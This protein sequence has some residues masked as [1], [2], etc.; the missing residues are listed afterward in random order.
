MTID[1]LIRKLETLKASTDEGGNTEV[2]FAIEAELPGE[3]VFAPVIIEHLEVR[4]LT[5][6]EELCN[7]QVLDKD[8]TLSEDEIA[9]QAVVINC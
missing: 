7:M 3:K 4:D 5:Y 9:G 6:R 2:V 8:H 1:E